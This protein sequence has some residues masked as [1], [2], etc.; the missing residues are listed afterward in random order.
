MSATSQGAVNL[1]AELLHFAARA[2][3]RFSVPA[4]LHSDDQLLGFLVNLMGPQKA[5]EEYFVGGDRDARQV[6]QLVGRWLPGRTPCRILEFAAGYGRVTR[7]LVKHLPDHQIVSSDI[8]PE[9]CRFMASALR[10][11][12][13][14]SCYEPAELNVGSGYDLVFALSL[15]SHL[16]PKRF[17]TWLAALSRATAEQGFLMFTTHG[18]ASME[19]A[20]PPA[21]GRLSKTLGF[22]FEPHSDQGDIPSSEYGTMV[23]TTEY[24]QRALA[25]YID[26]MRVESYCSRAWWNLE[27]EWLLRSTGQRPGGGR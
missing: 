22:V 7:H 1:T 17:G 4:D 13:R 3:E 21:V 6:A 26:N 2:A 15:F 25:N 10:C 14:P 24:V 9:A 27:D 11:D 18:E 8:H 12:V 19:G 5:V 16:P 20:S 23:V